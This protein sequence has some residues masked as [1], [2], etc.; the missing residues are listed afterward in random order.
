MSVDHCTTPQIFCDDVLHWAETYEGPPAMA[1]L[2]D[3]PYEL[4]F[5][6]AKWDASGIAF[7]PETWAALA[8]HLLP[9]AF[10]MAFASSRGYH[11]LACAIEDAGLILHPS[12]FNYRT[13]ETIDVPSLLGWSQGAGFPK[14]TQISS[15]VDDAWVQ[16]HYGGWCQC[17]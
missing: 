1:L 6:N 3:P 10:L 13:G 4:H 11:R 17:E 5:M 12:I 8:R 16:Q 14:A 2:A 7:R 9:G 15:Q